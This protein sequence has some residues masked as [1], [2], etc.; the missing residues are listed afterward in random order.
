M[1]GR[2]DRELLGAE[3]PQDHRF[4]RA[5]G[6]HG[7]LYRDASGVALG[8]GYASESGR[9]GPLAVRDSDL[10]GPGLGHL[11]QAV[12][13]RGR[14]GRVGAGRGR[15]GRRP[16]SCGRDCASRTFRS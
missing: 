16:R 13:S 9:I 15:R 4:L 6:R 10:M 12:Q 11:L 8:Y 3:H 14:P 1:V 5:E 2:L 7:F